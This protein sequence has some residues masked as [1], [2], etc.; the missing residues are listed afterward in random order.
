MTAEER[1]ESIQKVI[2]AFNDGVYDND[3]KYEDQ[4]PVQDPVVVLYLIERI[5]HYT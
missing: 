5:L 2:T 3:N 4:E 1:L